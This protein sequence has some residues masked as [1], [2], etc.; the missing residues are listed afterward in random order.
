MELYEYIIC[1]A[2]IAGLYSALNLI[3]KNN[4]NP[5]KILI[6]EK[7]YRV[8]GLIQT[9]KNDELNIKYENGAGRI[10]ENDEL[11]KSLIARFGLQDKIIKLNKNKEYRKVF[12]KDTIINIDIDRFDKLLHKIL[13]KNYKAI[14]DDSILINKSFKTLCEEEIGVEKTN[15]LIESFGYIDEFEKIN[16]KNGIEMFKK[17]FNPKLS[18]FTLKDGL[19][20]IVILL[21]NE[22]KKLGIQIILS[23]KIIN[24]EKNNSQIK[25]LTENFDNIANNYLTQNLILAIPHNSLLQIPFLNNIFNLLDSVE[26]SSLFRI[27]A[28]FPKDKNNQVWFHDIPKTSTNL[29][30]QQFIPINIESGLTMISYSD[31]KYAKEWQN[32]KINNLL[33]KEIMKNIRLLFSEKEIPDPIFLKSTFIYEATHLWKVNCDGDILQERIIKPYTDMNLFICG[34]SYSNNQ[35]WIEGALQTSNKVVNM[36]KTKSYIKYKS[37]TDSDIKKSKSLIII[38]NNVYDITINNWINNH[39]GGDIIKKYIGKDATKIF[40]YIHPKYANDLLEQLF[41]GVKV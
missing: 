27:Y 17:S 16:A 24:I 9:N 37:F 21:E 12:N 32:Y 34:E 29:N 30:I 31:T 33:E 6:I 11:L 2:G 22:L 8:G 40:K 5:K 3:E 7:S 38:N 41:V 13:Y 10:T 39:P 14:Y 15:L 25:V 18:Y 26:N 4:I 35:G 1:G 19:E 36:L 28:V 23:E 20:Q